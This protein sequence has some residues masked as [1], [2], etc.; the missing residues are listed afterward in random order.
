MT[1][2]YDLKEIRSNTETVAAEIKGF[3]EMDMNEKVLALES[4]LK[5]AVSD[6][7]QERRPKTVWISV[8]H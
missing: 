1:V 4:I 8:Q 6:C 2:R 5:E 7:K 3:G